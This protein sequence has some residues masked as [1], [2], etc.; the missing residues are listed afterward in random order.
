MNKF[1]ITTIISSVVPHLSADM[2]YDPVNNTIYSTPQNSSINNREYVVLLIE[3][4]IIVSRI[5]NNDMWYGQKT[6][7]QNILRQIFSHLQKIGTPTALRLLTDLQR[8]CLFYPDGS[9][10]IKQHLFKPL[11]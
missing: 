10:A 7:E 1:L 11:C 9:I 6:S 4:G 3:C 5:R 8:D 2:V